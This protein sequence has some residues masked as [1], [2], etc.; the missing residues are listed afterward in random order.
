MQQNGVPQGAC[1]AVDPCKQSAQRK[2]IRILYHVAVHQHE[3][4]GA[5]ENIRLVP[6][7]THAAVDQLAKEQF[8]PQ[9]RRDDRHQNHLPKCVGADTLLDQV[10]CRRTFQL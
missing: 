10:A 1:L 2:R 9:R 6:I 8:L 7:R 3:Q 5:G 4:A